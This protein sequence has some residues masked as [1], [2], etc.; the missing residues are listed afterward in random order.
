MSCQKAV[1]SPRAWD[2]QGC[3]NRRLVSAATA[4]KETNQ[5][6]MES[7]GSVVPIPDQL[8]VVVQWCKLKIN[9]YQS[10]IFEQAGARREVV[11]S[12]LEVETLC[13]GHP[14]AM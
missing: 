7:E 8:L 12:M 9:A 1:G 2:S 6:L 10:R 3:N 13:T 11:Y 4:E 5:G 14:L